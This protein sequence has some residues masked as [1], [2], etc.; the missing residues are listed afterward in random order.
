MK[1][2]DVKQIYNNKIYWNFFLIGISLFT[3]L[4][5]VLVMKS[6]YDYQRVIEVRDKKPVEKFKNYSY[7]IKINNENFKTSK[8]SSEKNLFS[9]IDSIENLN[10]SYIS[11]YEGFEITSINQ[12]PN[13]R[14]LVNGKEI[15]DKFFSEKDS[16]IPEKSEIE[17][18]F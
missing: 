10:L 8:F 18:Y 16:L 3:Y 15:K 13:Y 14:I 6:G 2:F 1:K 11:Y 17:I 7:E 4:I 12:N 5:I 9:L